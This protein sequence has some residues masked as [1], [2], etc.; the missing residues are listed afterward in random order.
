VLSSEALARG[1]IHVT[2]TYSS[3]LGLPYG[4][5]FLASNATRTKM[6]SA[7]LLQM[8]ID[9]ALCGWCAAAKLREAV[10]WQEEARMVYNAQFVECKRATIPRF[11]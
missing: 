5:E 9:L 11:E 3:T 1:C 4:V 10:D 2:Q 8:K 7:G 6:F